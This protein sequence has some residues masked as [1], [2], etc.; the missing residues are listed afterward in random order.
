VDTA[1]NESGYRVERSPDGSSFS[2]IAQLGSG[3]MSYVDSGLASGMAFYYRVYAYNSGGAS[4][5][6]NSASGQ[7]QAAAPAPVSS[8][9]SAPGSPSPANGATNVNTNVTLS[10]TASNATN[11]DVYVNGALAGSNITTT[12]LRVGS[13]PNATPYS[14]L[15]VAKNA[16]G[17]TSGPTWSFTT[18]AAPGK[19]RK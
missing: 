3:A 7:T 17:S 2:Q 1:T 12:S 13:M 9:P 4:G 8:V 15:V 19:G 11:Y 6:S 18:K 14:W 5:Y 10:W 16:A